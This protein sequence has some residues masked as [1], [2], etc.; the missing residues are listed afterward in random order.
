[1]TKRSDSLTRSIDLASA[2]KRML[3]GAAIALV[4]ITLFL[5]GVKSPK[6]EWGEFWMVRPLIIVPLAGA[7]GGF[8]YYFV[9]RQNLR[10][11]SQRIV[12]TVLGLFG[13]II[14]LWMGFVLGLDG[15]LWD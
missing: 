3:L 15:T 2:G 14:A 10:S 6:P 7:A 4:L 13:Y 12:F 5:L 1:M 8:F 9:Q 11:T